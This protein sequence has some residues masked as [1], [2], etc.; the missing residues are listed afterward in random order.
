MD[1]FGSIFEP[2]IKINILRLS[3]L[4]TNW[5]FHD[6]KKLLLMF[7]DVLI[8]LWF[9]LNIEILLFSYTYRDTYG[10]MLLCLVLFQNKIVDKIK[11]F[12]SW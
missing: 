1:L 5:I 8:V 9:C 3:N 7:I 2:S 12:L 10:N 11:V 6:I 4:T